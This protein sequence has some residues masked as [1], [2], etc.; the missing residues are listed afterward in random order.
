MASSLPTN[1]VLFLTGWKLDWLKL[2][3][4]Q[5]FLMNLE[6]LVRLIVMQKNIGIWRQI[7]FTVQLKERRVGDNQRHLSPENVAISTY[8][9]TNPNVSGTSQ[10]DNGHK[11][12]DSSLK[13]SNQFGLNLPISA[14]GKIKLNP[15]IK[16][17]NPKV[18]SEAQEKNEIDTSRSKSLAK[19]RA[20]GRG[21]ARRWGGRGKWAS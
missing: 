5:E 18:N 2:K 20:R 6:W 11:S 4:I 15:S 10:T 1:R 17:A 3:M 9:V 7:F 21:R 16:L 13:T 8:D 14:Q 19:N 12:V